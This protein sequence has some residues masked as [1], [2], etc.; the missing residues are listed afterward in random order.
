M[1]RVGRSWTAYQNFR[2]AFNQEKSVSQKIIID[3]DPLGNTS[4]ETTGFTGKSCAD[5]TREL[6]RALGR[7]DRDQKKPEYFQQAAAGQ[8]VKTSS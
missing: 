1:S 2:N 8:S 4:V 7:V 3:I 6:E 5:A